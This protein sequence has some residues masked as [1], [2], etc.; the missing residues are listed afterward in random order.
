MDRQIVRQGETN[1]DRQIVRQ[2]ETNMDRQIFRQE[3]L[4]WID[5]LLDRIDKT[6]DIWIEEKSL[7][8][9]KSSFLN[10]CAEG[11]LI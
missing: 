5:R 9:Y 8:V 11:K 6:I 2:G 3:R 1:M 7:S 10:F 4:I